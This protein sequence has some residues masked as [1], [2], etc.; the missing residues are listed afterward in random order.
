M[1]DLLPYHLLRARE[2]RKLRR[3]FNILSEHSSKRISERLIQT[4]GFIFCYV[5][6]SRI[7]V[8][9]VI[10][11]FL[12]KPVLSFILGGSYTI[13]VAGMLCLKESTKMSVMQS[14]RKEATN[15]SRL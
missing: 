3:F 12:S 6:Q 14:C 2:K 9:V 15:I 5:Q 13:C 4:Q 10:F 7:K 1:Y 8:F 11:E